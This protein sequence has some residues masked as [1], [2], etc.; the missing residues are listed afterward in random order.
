MHQKTS[1]GWPARLLIALLFCLLSLPAAIGFVWNDAA[2]LQKLENRKMATM[3]DRAQFR[4]DPARYIKSVDNYLKDRVGLR[5]TAN[6]LYRKL[7]YYVLK[8]PPLPNVS[9]GQDGFVFMNSHRVNQPNFV[10]DLLCGQ[11]IKP[12]AKLFEE[13]DRTFAS[14]NSYY[15]DLGYKV[16]FAAAPTNVAL[17]PDKLPLAV[18]K[19]YRDACRAYPTSDHLLAQMDRLGKSDGRYTIY[20][21]LALFQAH[22][23]EPYFYPKEKWHW[24][25]R[26]AFLFARDLLVQSGMMETL[27]VDDPAVVG[28]VSDDLTM[29]FGFSRE[30]QAMTYPYANF[31]TTVVEPPW[32]G[33][34]VKNG[35]LLHFT[36]K[37]SLSGKRALLM[38]NSFGIELAP[39]LAKGFSE[40]YFFNL[41]HVKPEEEERFFAGIVEKTR[42]NHIYILFDDAGIIAAPQRLGAFVNLRD[43]QQASG[44]AAPPAGA[45]EAGAPRP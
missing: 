36:T 41:N 35:G 40:L 7:R 43:K 3:P 10:F 4:K 1:F 8:D 15:A 14:A 5:R 33:A 31:E 17:Y 34:L 28:T 22:R 20:Y 27:K 38:S 21:P 39:H 11:Q 32:T 19:K 2:S 37:N 12:T 24:S 13:M 30:V 42:P 6:E 26:S 29:F 45:T 25:G 16:T 9:I 18:E 23:D 44:A